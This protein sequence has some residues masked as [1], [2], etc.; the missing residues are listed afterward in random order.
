MG[1]TA[2]SRTRFD[3]S[4]SLLVVFEFALPCA[5]NAHGGDD[6]SIAELEASRASQAPGCC[7]HQSSSRAAGGGAAA[8]GQMGRRERS[9]PRAPAE[10]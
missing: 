10:A 9:Q 7:E 4:T 8:C 3:R 1:A 6:R 2:M 5:D